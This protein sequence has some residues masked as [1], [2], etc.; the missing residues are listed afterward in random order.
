MVQ[1]SG[2]GCVLARTAVVT[3]KC[4]GQSITMLAGKVLS[5]MA[6]TGDH[7]APKD[8][9]RERRRICGSCEHCQ[10]VDLPGGAKYPGTCRICGCIITLKTRLAAESCPATPPR[11]AAI[12][13]LPGSES[14][15][16]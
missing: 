15:K 11:W 9:I 13:T 4:C 12:P 8:V 6:P 16:R 3:M 7:L 2:T 14:S 5:A 1:P 10:L